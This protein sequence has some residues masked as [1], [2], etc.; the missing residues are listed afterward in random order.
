MLAATA[1]APGGRHRAEQSPEYAV[2]RDM[3]TPWSPHPGAPPKQD[4]KNAR[5]GTCSLLVAV[6]PKAGQRTIKLTDHR[7]KIDFVDFVPSP[8]RQRRRPQH[9]RRAQLRRSRLKGNVVLAAPPKEHIQRPHARPMDAWP[10]SEESLPKRLDRSAPQPGTPTKFL[11]GENRIHIRLQP[12]TRPDVDGQH[13][14]RLGT[15]E[16][17]RI[18]PAES[19]LPQEL[20]AL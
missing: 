1:A 8:A 20:L 4:Y 7:P 6:E 19:K 16:N 5:V 9:L 2:L 14:T 15:L 12:P 3:R 11:V 10:P 18:Q 17:R 13:E